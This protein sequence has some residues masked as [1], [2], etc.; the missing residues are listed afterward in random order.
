M[1]GLNEEEVS[2]STFSDAF[3]E[4]FMSEDD[5]WNSSV[6]AWPILKRLEIVSLATE[7]LSR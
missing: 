5:F 2:I 6:V 4:I 3:N 7:V 1:S